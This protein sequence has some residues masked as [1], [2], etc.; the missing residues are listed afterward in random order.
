MEEEGL[1]K[2]PNLELAQLRFQ[3]VAGVAEDRAAA[4]EKLLV[5]VKADN[6]APFYKQLAADLAFPVD[7]ALLASMEAA[8][9]A[10]IA[11]FDDQL[12]EAQKSQG[13]TEVRESLL[14]KAEYICK[15]GDKERATKAFA[16]AAEKTVASGQRLD[17]QFNLIRLGLFH[18]DH[19]IIKAGI[20]KAKQLIEEGGDW[21]RRNR[22]K[23][24]EAVYCMTVRDFKRASELLRDGLATFTSYE[25]MTYKQFVAYTVI[26][27]T[28]ALSRV[29]LKSKIVDASEVKE[30]IYDLPLIS[31]Y[32]SSLYESRFA[33]FFQSLAGLEGELQADRYLAAHVRFYTREMRILAYTQF[34]ESYRS[35]ALQSVADHFGVSIGFVD[36]ELSRFI[37]AG[38]L[39]C[40]IDKVAG[41]VE[42][43]R[44]DRKNAQ[45]QSLIKSGD[46][47]LN[48]LQK[49]S[50]VITI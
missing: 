16:A 18:M 34:L 48:R 15:I 21:D 47:L 49:L 22:L 44:P 14:K 12:A 32:L 13:E 33:D 36:R 5:A 35:V 26:V 30:A 7:A 45:Y 46:Q 3:L 2:N 8:N 11:K 10:E 40:K 23:T 24:Y 37:A 1:A 9:D 19:D 25:L 31:N 42:A 38:R 20:A 41:I 29:D 39:H 17:L 6:M 50:R 28:F 4:L 27:S 43:T